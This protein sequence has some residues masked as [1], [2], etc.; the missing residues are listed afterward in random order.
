M[1]PSPITQPITTSPRSASQSISQ[2]IGPPRRGPVAAWIV[3]ELEV[4]P[5]AIV[6]YLRLSGLIV[7]HSLFVE[8]ERAA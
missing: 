5:M 7:P 1:L 8:S 2:P 3:A 6:D 4:L